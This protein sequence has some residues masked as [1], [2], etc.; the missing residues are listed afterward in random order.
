MRSP[1]ILTSLVV[2]ASLAL[3]APAYLHAQQSGTGSADTA[4]RR[5]LAARIVAKWS[6]HIQEVY[7]TSPDDW[8]SQMSSLFGSV[9]LDTLQRAADAG[10]FDRMNDLLIGNTSAAAPDAG[11]VNQLLG[12]TA[13]DLVF[14]PV[15]PCRIFDTR[16]AGGPIASNTTRNFDV[17]AVGNYSGQGGDASNCGVGAAGA[18]AAAAINFTV[19]ST[20]AGGYITAYPLGTTQPLAATVN[21]TTADEVRGNLAIVKLDQGPAADELSVYAA[22]QTHLVGDIV[23]YFTNPEATPFDCVNT[24]LSNFNIAA[25]TTNFFNNPACPAGYRATTPYCWT[26]ASGVYS[27]GQGFNANVAGNATFCAWQNTTGVAQQVY[28][29]NVCCRIPGR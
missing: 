24:A 20:V 10:N 16:L 13:A 8:A 11:T 19:V 25:N 6:N 7:G 3:A 5:D 15:T 28:G 2:L 23:G 17:T 1:R 29:G 21:W 9:P 4:Q 27:Q 26:A 18:F 14:V 22:S 12:D